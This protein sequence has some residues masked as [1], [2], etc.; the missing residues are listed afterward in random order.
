MAKNCTKNANFHAK[1]GEALFAKRELRRHFLI[2]GGHRIVRVD[3]FDDANQL[4]DLFGFDK[5]IHTFGHGLVKALI[6]ILD[7]RVKR[8]TGQILREALPIELFAAVARRYAVSADKR[9]KG[10]LLLGR[11]GAS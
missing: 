6:V 2:Y 10:Q 1:G 8:R 7:G 11:G 5:Q 4:Y 3:L 9:L